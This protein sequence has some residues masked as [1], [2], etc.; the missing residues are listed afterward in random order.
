MKRATRCMLGYSVHQRYVPNVILRAVVSN[1]TCHALCLP[2]PIQNTGA[3][4]FHS[5][6]NRVR[7][8]GGAIFSKD[9]EITYFET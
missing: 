4:K 6:H 1:W 2:G 3:V 5:I 7:E 9:A 8:E